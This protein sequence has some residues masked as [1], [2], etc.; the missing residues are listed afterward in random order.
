MSLKNAMLNAQN[1]TLTENGALTHRSTK[2]HVLDLFAL[3]GSANGINV[4]LLIRNALNENPVL[5]I[6]VIFY[7]SDI[8]EGQGRRAFF[9]Q[10]L[11]VILSE[12]VDIARKL[13]SFVPEFGRWD[14]LYWFVGTILER[15]ALV[16]L[17]QEVLRAIDSGKPALIFKW[18][19]SADASSA[20][21]K[22]DA[23]ITRKF[24]KLT[25]REYRKML[26]KG[27]EMLKE[28]V[29][30]RKM[31]AKEW[32]DID[33]SKV[34]SVAMKRYRKAFISHNPSHFEGFIKKVESGEAKINSSVLYPH[35]IVKAGESDRGVARRALAA[36]WNALPNYLSDKVRALA[37]VDTSGSMMGDPI[38]IAASIGIYLA[39]RMKGEFH[40]SVISFSEVARLFELPNGDVFDKFNYLRRNSIVENTN[41]QS[42]FELLLGTAKQAH[43]PAEEMP[44]RIIIMSDMEFDQAVAGQYNYRTGRYTQTSTNLDA[45]RSKYAAAGYEFPQI[46]FWNVNARHQ[47][48]P[49]T[50]ND[51]GV[52]LVSGYSPVIMKS[53]LSDDPYITP[54]KAMLNTIEVERYAFVDGILA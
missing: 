15:D 24:F 9:R 21:T 40:N 43:V 26:S 49:A 4:D 31:S 12:D 36:Q 44:N 38:M 5:A 18:L 47:Q 33:Y 27:R 37:V 1:F 50:M 14:Y 23:A 8:R 19:A 2:S 53:V 25:P 51:S 13:L 52:I 30:E 11:K 42:V 16:L 34:P 46:I 45:I 3:G 28:A 48:T 10:A 20:E 7:L 29:V 17:R 22:R 6:K 41:L 35:D 32:S 39:E 54:Y